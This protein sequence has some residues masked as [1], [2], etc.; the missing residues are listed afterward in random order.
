MSK[1]KTLQEWHALV[2]ELHAAVGR[3]M[4]LGAEFPPTIP[5]SMALAVLS[6]VAVSLQ[7]LADLGPPVDDEPA[8]DDDEDDAGAVAAEGPDRD[9]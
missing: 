7:M 8:E 3:V 2:G 4:K 1:P 6:T 9:A 5:L